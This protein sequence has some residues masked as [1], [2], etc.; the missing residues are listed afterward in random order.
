MSAC[1]TVARNTK[2]AGCIVCSSRLFQQ[3]CINQ[4]LR[5]VSAS[6]FSCKSKIDLTL[7]AMAN[8]NGHKKAMS[9]AT[10]DV[11]GVYPP[12]ATPF[13]S[14]ENIDYKKLEQN[15]QRWDKIP[16]RGNSIKAK[17]INCGLIVT[18]VC[19]GVRA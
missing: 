15:F 4:M 19:R 7:R 2:Q 16:F 13:D 17:L 14:N 12:V 8:L 1:D 18:C 11:A 9:T 10:L 3:L 5:R 6:A